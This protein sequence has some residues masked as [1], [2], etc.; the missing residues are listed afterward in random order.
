MYHKDLQHFPISFFAI[1]MGLAGLAIALK[2]ASDTICIPNWA[3]ETVAIFSGLI[4]IIV[5]IFYV[6]KILK[7]TAAVKKEFLHPV[8]ISFFPTI[9]ISLL[10]LSIAFLESIPTLSS[11]LWWTGTIMHLTFTIAIISIWI[12]GSQFDI[13]H[14]SPAWFIP[15]VG[16]IIVPIA[17]VSHAQIEILWFFFSIGSLF[18]LIILVVFFYRIIF[19]HPLPERL[20]PT[21]M[22]LLAPPAIGAISLIKLNSG[23]TLPAELFYY[24]SVFF[25]ILLAAQF[26]LFNKLR[27]FLSWW[28]Y[29][30]PIAA[31][32]IATF[33]MADYKDSF[34]LLIVAKSLLVLLIILIV[35]L[36]VLTLRAIFRNEIC[37]TEG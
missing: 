22:I 31:F 24:I 10:L 30:F 32:T 34:Y 28:A 16:N 4:F 15:A 33:S 2:K 7:F 20:V 1:V 23:L 26:G 9:S 17:G 5:A 27:F 21:L 8:K 35:L 13:K 25:F 6:F 14:L 37:Q 3:G 29:S 11:H 36:S 18:W 12:R 19:H